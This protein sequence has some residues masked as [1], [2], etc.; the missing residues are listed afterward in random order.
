MSKFPRRKSSYSATS[1]CVEARLR[2]E[3]G[4][5]VGDSKLSPAARRLTFTDSTWTAFLTDTRRSRG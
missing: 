3:K 1:N 2:R 5:E 4:V